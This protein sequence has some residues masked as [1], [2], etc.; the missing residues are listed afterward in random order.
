MK[1]YSLKLRP[2]SSFITPWQA[3]TIFGSL[4]WLKAWRDGN[5]ALLR[6]LDEYKSGNPAFI[7]SDAM[8]GDLLPAP[9]HLSFSVSSSLDIKKIR[10]LQ[11]LEPECFETVRKG[12]FSN[13]SDTDLKPFK[14]MTTLH[15]SINRLSGTTGDEGSLFELAEY[16]LDSEEAKA[17]YMTIYLKIRADK[18]DEVFSLFRDLS[19]TGYGAKKSSGKGSF[20]ILGGV[21]EF[22]GF[23]DFD[24]SNGFTSLSNFMP[25]EN[26]P[27]K[28]YYQ[29]MVKYGKLGGEF[30]SSENPFKKPLMMLTAGSSFYVENDI[31][32]FYGR[33]VEE[34][35]PSKPD[36]VQYSYAFA[37]PILLSEDVSD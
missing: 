2:K 27:V 4:C 10:K 8:P 31:K 6:F 22:T 23:N 19:I 36:V 15:S 7:L 21:D 13:L 35:A 26:D 28:G 11:W 9:A 34:V 1:T 17:D 20:E 25:A 12:D 30:A 37:V 24:E 29:T 33:M 3:D 18:E 16:V 5:D 32:P 14:P